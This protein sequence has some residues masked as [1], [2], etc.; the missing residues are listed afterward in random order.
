V[1]VGWAGQEI[2]NLVVST[3]EWRGVELSDA[4]ELDRI[5]F[6]GYLDGLHDAGWRGD[7]LEVR[8]GEWARPQL[9]SPG[10]IA[11]LL[12]ESRHAWLERLFGLTIEEFADHWASKER[13]LSDWETEAREL[14]NA[15][16]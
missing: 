16:R 14:L 12:D 7:P 15:L 4:K 6:D 10:L 1:G 5:V 13:C 11:I 9:V 8:L 2:W 3:L